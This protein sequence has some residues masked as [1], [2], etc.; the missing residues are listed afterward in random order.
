MEEAK[1]VVKHVLLAKFKDET[2]AEKIEELI[3]G[4]ANLVNLIEPM[5]AFQWGKDV[6]IENLHQGFTHVF[7]STFESTEGI[8]EYVAHPVHV[9]FANLFLGHLE[10]VL[11]I[12]YKPTIARC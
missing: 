12:D 1:G 4:Y 5:K 11:V 3:K 10:K 8:A 7:E 2:T 6:S 9:Q